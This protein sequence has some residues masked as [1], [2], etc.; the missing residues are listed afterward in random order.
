MVENKNINYMLKGDAL[1]NFINSYGF[2]FHEEKDH[3]FMKN[4]NPVSISMFALI[5]LAGKKERK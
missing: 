4:F 1:F 5:N 2:F 3:S